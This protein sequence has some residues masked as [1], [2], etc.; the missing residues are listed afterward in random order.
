MLQSLFEI[1]IRDLEYE[2][3][4]SQTTNILY[5]FHNKKEKHMVHVDTR[6]PLVFNFSIKL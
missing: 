6:Y 4:S 1:E 3:G 2:Y 5:I